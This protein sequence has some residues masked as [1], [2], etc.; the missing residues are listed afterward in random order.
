MKRNFYPFSQFSKKFASFFLAFILLSGVVA[1]SQTFS[2]YGTGDA[3][4]T[5]SNNDFHGGGIET[6]VKF[7]VS[8]SGTVSA[9]RFYRGTA[10]DNQTYTGSLWEIVTGSGVL[11]ASGTLTISGSPA[12]GWQ[13]I[14]LSS[15]YH[16]L[17]GK[18]YVASYHSPGGYYALSGNPSPDVFDDEDISDPPFIL[19]GFNTSVADPANPGNGVYEYTD[20]PNNIP[21]YPTNNGNGSNYWADVVFTTDFSLPVTL[22]DLKA[23]AVS[24]DITVSWKTNYETNNKGFEIQR[25]N[26]GADWYPVTFING[27][28]ESTTVQNYSYTDKSLAPGLYY[29]RV[30]Q[31]D[32]DSKSKNS[33]VVTASISGK[34]Q[35]L[36]YAA[37]PITNA[38]TIRFDLPKAQKVR[39]SVID[40]AGREVKV[41]TNKTGEAG[42][43][44]VILNTTGLSRQMYYLRLQTENGI[45]TKKIVVQ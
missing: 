42:S 14:N 33:S 1:Y 18:T 44:Q 13:Q 32:F 17:P 6:G 31:V 30:K 12:A 27:A 36:L 39:L 35:V 26:N 37:N 29:Y 4:A 19:I 10:S 2:I 23:T 34:G 5:P 7:R 8:Q 45:I 22:S 38:A 41:L 43:H 9:I 16:I 3:P 15:S 40:M 21:T 24:K 28:G 20:A 11:R 25:S